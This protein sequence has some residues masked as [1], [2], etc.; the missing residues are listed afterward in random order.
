[1][2]FANGVWS[3]LEGDGLQ[4]G[5]PL[6]PGASIGEMAEGEGFAGLMRFVA[7]RKFFF[8]CGFEK[9][10]ACSERGRTERGLGRGR[11]GELTGRDIYVIR[12]AY[13]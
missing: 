3:G 10:G 6:P 13:R 2:R 1:M 4:V 12:L 9:R 5:Y 11:R 8:L 7:S